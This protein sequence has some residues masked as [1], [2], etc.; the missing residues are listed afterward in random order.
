MSDGAFLSISAL[1]IDFSGRGEAAV[2][3]LDPL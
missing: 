3:I 2:E 1:V